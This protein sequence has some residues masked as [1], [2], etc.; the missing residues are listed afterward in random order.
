MWRRTCPKRCWPSTL[1]T[2][3]RVA[4]VSVGTYFASNLNLQW[5]LPLALACVGPLGLL[6][7]LPFIPGQSLTPSVP[8]GQTD[9]VGRVS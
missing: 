4:W 1:L 5:R 6:A 7:G 9:N 3:R 8:L 2:E